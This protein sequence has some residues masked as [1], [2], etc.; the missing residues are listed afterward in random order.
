MCQRR[1]ATKNSHIQLVGTILR[2]IVGDIDFKGPVATRVLERFV[3]I[4]VDSSLIIDRAKVEKY[5]IVR[6]PL[7]WHIKGPTVPAAEVF[8]AHDAYVIMSI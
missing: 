5:M 1:S 7:A 3:A 4:N 2:Q 8:L 6:I